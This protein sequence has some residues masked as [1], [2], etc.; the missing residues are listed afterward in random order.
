MISFWIVAGIFSVAVILAVL[1][2]LWR[3]PRN[4]EA[5]LIVLNRR[6]FQER[7]TELEA[8]HDE[9]RIDTDTFR[10]LKTDLQ[11][12]LLTLD[13]DAPALHETRSWR[14]PLVLAIVTTAGSLLFYSTVLRSPEV[15]QWWQVQQSVGPAAQRLME[16][17]PPSDGENKHSLQEIIQGM[18]Y[19]L[20]QNPEQPEGWFTLGVA[21]VQA[22]MLAPAMTAFERAWRLKPEETR[23]ALTFAQARIFSNQGQLDDLSRSLLSSIV[24][25]EPAHEGALLL[26]GL[27]AWRSEEYALAV[28]VLEQLIQVRQQREPNDT[29]VAMQEVAKALA[30]AR[31]RLQ[32]GPVT[33]SARLT[34]TVQV[35]KGVSERFAPD[36]VVYIFARALKGPPMPLAVV[37]RKASELPITVELDDATSMLPDQPLSSVQEIVIEARISRHGSPEK[38]TGDIEAVAVPVRQG[39]DSQKVALR[40]NSVI[41]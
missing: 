41:P 32:A 20:Q 14:L 8:D 15:S 21:Y 1:W 35:D 22:E 19:Q 36:D 3:A 18:Q 40:L 30:D 9:G 4:N 16:G 25:R 27:G 2:P 26:L 12:N 17:K 13:I 33:R 7:M 39:A 37:K 28:P 23:Y 31:T 34:V 10:D 5:S 38:R 24:Q 29:S 6:V 11:R